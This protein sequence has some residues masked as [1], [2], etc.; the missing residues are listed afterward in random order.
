M[1]RKPTGRHWHMTSISLDEEARFWLEAIARERGMSQSAV[2]RELI[3]READRFRE[4]KEKGEV[5]KREV[6]IS[7]SEDDFKILE[8]LRIDTRVGSYSD[9]V[10]EMLHSMDKAR[11][12]ELYPIELDWRARRHIQELMKVMSDDE[13]N[14]ALLQAIGNLY[15]NR[16]VYKHKDQEVSFRIS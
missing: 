10:R 6:V 5:Q 3:L 9:V 7:L 11:K 12:L 13:L 2:V 15:M 14:H 16:I 1:G 4:Q 8:E